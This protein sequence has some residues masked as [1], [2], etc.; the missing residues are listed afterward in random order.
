MG[1][2]IPK[3]E[4]AEQKRFPREGDNSPRPRE[5][6]LGQQEQQLGGRE[7]PVSESLE[8]HRE[9]KGRGCACTCA[10]VV[11]RGRE[12]GRAQPWPSHSARTEGTGS[13]GKQ[14]DQQGGG[15]CPES[16]GQPTPQHP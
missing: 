11:G 6:F 3:S 10:R 2:L 5:D 14:G 16:R 8:V 12:V 4:V 15:G 9:P 7:S 1:P 13:A